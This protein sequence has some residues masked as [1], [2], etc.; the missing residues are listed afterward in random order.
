MFS[1]VLDHGNSSMLAH[2][3]VECAGRQQP[4]AFWRMHDLLFERQDQLWNLKP[5]LLIGWAVE[6]DLDSSTLASCLAEPAIAEKVDRLDQARRTAGV[7]L[8]PTFRVNDRLVEGGLPYSQFVQLFAD[9]GV[10]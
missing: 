1:H 6:L 9:M 8:R 2:R 3:A 10:Q 4:L 5:D 7:R